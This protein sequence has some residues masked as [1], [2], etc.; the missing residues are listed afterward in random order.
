MRIGPTPVP[1]HVTDKLV[2]GPWTIAAAIFAG[3]AA[4]AALSTLVVAVLQIRIAREEVELVRED[5]KNN[6]R[7]I[8]EQLR[9]P[10][11]RPI[12]GP[13]IQVGFYQVD[14]PASRNVTLRAHVTNVGERVAKHLAAEWLI[15]PA[16]LENCD[17]YP[18]R[19]V[20]GEEYCIFEAPFR[21]D[22]IFWP[23]GV[24]DEMQPANLSLSLSSFTCEGGILLRFYDD[25]GT[26]P[27]G[28]WYRYRYQAEITGNLL[29]RLAL[30][31]LFSLLPI[32]PEKGES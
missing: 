3:A 18:K 22:L 28:T 32:S 31:P 26:Y 2:E 24:P 14:Q 17:Q 1:V 12:P 29:S 13:R 20:F 7:M 23:N 4:L 25:A 9:H 21:G 8:D 27:R 11:L 5:L 19:S 10:D 6:R 30:E 16:F 15:P